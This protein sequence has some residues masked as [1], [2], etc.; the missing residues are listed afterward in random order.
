LPDE[1]NIAHVFST[2]PTR[3]PAYCRHRSNAALK[4]AGSFVADTMRAIK[5]TRNQINT[6]QVAFPAHFGT[7][8]FQ[9]GMPLHKPQ[10]SP[11]NIPIHIERLINA[12]SSSA[13]I[14]FSIA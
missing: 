5:D 3:L 9:Y 8:A 10:S 12:E 1:A 4:A 14:I 6:A 7:P 11:L 13:K 2:I